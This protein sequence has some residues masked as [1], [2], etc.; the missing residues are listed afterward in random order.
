MYQAKHCMQLA[1]VGRPTAADVSQYAREFPQEGDQ[2]RRVH[3]QSTLTALSTAGGLVGA[4]G[5]ALLHTR[6]A[7]L[8]LASAFL[9]TF[10]SHVVG[11]DVSDGR[12]FA[13]FQ[14]AGVA[15]G[16]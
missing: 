2:L 3:A 9:G 5:W 7:P 8:V 4:T 16:F 6:S 13:R 12:V 10:S 11:D 14:R 15:G 1:M